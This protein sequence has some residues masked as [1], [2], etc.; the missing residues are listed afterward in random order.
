MNLSHEY[1]ARAQVSARLGE[2]QQCRQGRRLARALR[3]EPS[4]RAARSAGPTRP[5]PHALSAQHRTTESHDPMNT[6]VNTNPNGT[7]TT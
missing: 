1:L 7:D 3:T 6:T 2:A 5:R 4:R